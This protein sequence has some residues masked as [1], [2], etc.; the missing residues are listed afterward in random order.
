M[1]KQISR[2][3]IYQS[4]KVLALFVFFI[5]AIMVI[6]FVLWGVAHKENAVLILLFM[7]FFGLLF[8]FC[9]HALAF[10]FYNLI[11]GV[12]GGIEVTF[13]DIE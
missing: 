8:A 11:A 1:K 3:S 12:F 5:Y 7:P 13:K 4:S 10:W 6:P 2:F 9:F